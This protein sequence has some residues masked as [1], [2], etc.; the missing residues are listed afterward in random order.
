L[1]LYTLDTANRLYWDYGKMEEHKKIVKVTP[2]KK[3]WELSAGIQTY[4][5]P[6]HP[7]LSY[8]YAAVTVYLNKSLLH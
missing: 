3:A 1:G 8:I 6:I 4:T 2:A 5:T 7:L